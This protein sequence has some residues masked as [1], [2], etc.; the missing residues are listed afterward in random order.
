MDFA[1]NDI[2][3]MLQDS[4]SKFVRNEYDFEIRQRFAK[5]AL[6]FNPENWSLFAGL[7]W[8]ALPFQESYGGLDR[9]LV[10]LMVL[11]TGW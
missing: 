7:G 10:D 6:G 9:T 1:L 8:L 2:Q 4:A 5:S 11:Q 3:Q